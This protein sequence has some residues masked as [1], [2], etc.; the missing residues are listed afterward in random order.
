MKINKYFS[1]FLFSKNDRGLTA[2]KFVKF[3]LPSVLL[4]KQFFEDFSLNTY[5]KK[6]NI[7]I[8]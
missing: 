1:I 2:K 5:S 8:L 3:F 7:T 6:L 4:K